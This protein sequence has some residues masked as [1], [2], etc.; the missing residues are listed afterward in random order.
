MY[1]YSVSLDEIIVLRFMNN[2]KLRV[3]QNKFTKSKSRTQNS[4]GNF[5]ITCGG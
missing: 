4:N 2:I 3:Q 5:L 1:I